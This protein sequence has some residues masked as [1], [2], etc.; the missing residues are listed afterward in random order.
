MTKRILL[1]GLL[2]LHIAVFAQEKKEIMQKT[3]W[4]GYT[5]V[6][7]TSNFDD[8]TSVMLRRLKFWLKS[9]PEFSSHW[10]YKV[11]VLFTSWMQE[12]FF[13]QDAKVSYK[14]GLFSFDVGQFVPQY[15]LQWTQP[16]Y[17]IPAIERAIA[18]NALHPDG[19]LGIR[20]LGVQANF[21][22]E[23]NILEAHLGVFNGYGIKEYRF[24]N[25]GYMLTHKLAIDI[26]LQNHKLQFGY[27]LMYRYAQNLQLKK[28]LHD[29]L[30]YTGS[31]IRYNFFVL[32][33]S[34]YFDIQAEYLNADF[35]NNL[36]ANGYYIL[37]TINIKKSQIVLSVENYKSTYGQMQEP[38]YRIA[39]NY[40]IN[41]NK[42][43]L[44]FDNYFRIAD[45][46]IENY[47]ASVEL[48]MFFK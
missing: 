21:H 37:S 39:Y 19:S 16:D 17:K 31:D 24:N 5:Q 46:G 4:N 22:T 32:F 9:T 12:K 8:Y 27:S 38:Y 11:Q 45:G 36:N 14:T 15:S 30:F 33:N 40:L 48:Q 7:A 25:K 2:S 43:K 34:K 26:P 35:E 28:V 20:D 29:T 44:F 47:Y 23:N 1:I 18:V 42:L 3:K 13:L 10:S 6:R 41:K